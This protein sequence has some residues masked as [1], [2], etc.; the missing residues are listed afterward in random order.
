MSPA[1]IAEVGAAGA[2]G[3]VARHLV[4]VAVGARTRSSLPI[5][6]M[7]INLTGSLVLGVL[8]GLVLWHHASPTVALVGGSGF[9]GGYTTFSTASLEGVRLVQAGRWRAAAATTAA[10]AVG[11]VAAGALGL[12]VAR[13]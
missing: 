9:C 6:T 10:T 11:A 8:A 13:L 3:A 2:A 7:G 12:A 4:A 5:A 1:A